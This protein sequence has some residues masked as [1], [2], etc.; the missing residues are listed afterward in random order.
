[1]VTMT[2]D[3]WMV[4]VEIDKSV[5][6]VPLPAILGPANDPAGNSYGIDFSF[7]DNDDPNETDNRGGD[8][9]FSTAYDWADP[10]SGGGFPSKQASL[11]GEL[12]APPSTCD[13]NSGGDLDGNGKVEFADFLILSG[14]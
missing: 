7:R 13:P 3:G 9:F 2:D 4:E 14:K 6:D 1:M 11:W 5:F 10:T 12:I 8:I